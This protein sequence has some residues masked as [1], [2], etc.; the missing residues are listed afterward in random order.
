MQSRGVKQAV[1]HRRASKSNNLSCGHLLSPLANVDALV[2]AFDYL[3]IKRV[4]NQGR[5]RVRL[6]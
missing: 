5:G 4:F 3:R 1:A 2:A 6:R